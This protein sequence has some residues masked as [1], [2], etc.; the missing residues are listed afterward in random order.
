MFRVQFSFDETT[1]EDL[2]QQVCVKLFDNNYARLRSWRGQ[3][4]LNTWLKVICRNLAVDH[5]RATARR[6]NELPLTST[7]ADDGL[8]QAPDTLDTFATVQ[9]RELSTNFSTLLQSFSKID[10]NLIKLYYVQG[11]SYQEIS[12]F[13]NLTESNIG[14]RLSRLRKKLKQS[15]QSQAPWMV[16]DYYNEIH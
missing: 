1:T 9:A 12:Q 11:Y 6:I 7:D 14:A 10:R 13:S 15:I 2:I 8:T 3:C 16:D 5:L 4:S